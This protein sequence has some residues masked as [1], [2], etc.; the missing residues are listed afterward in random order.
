MTDGFVE[1]HDK[2]TYRIQEEC[3]VVEMECASLAAVAQRDVVAGLAPIAN[4]LADLESMTNVTG[5]RSF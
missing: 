3:S 5:V 1:K 4:S 2:V